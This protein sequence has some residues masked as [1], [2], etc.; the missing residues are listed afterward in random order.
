MEPKE[1]EN[2]T[3]SSIVEKDELSCQQCSYK[4][5]HEFDLSRHT[6]QMH[7]LLE[8]HSVDV[9]CCPHCE[10]ST[11]YLNNLKRHKRVQHDQKYR[12][13]YASSRRPA[14]DLRKSNAVHEETLAHK[15]IKCSFCDF[16]SKSNLDMKTHQAGHLKVNERT[17]HPFV[18]SG[19]VFGPQKPANN[20]TTKGS[21]LRCEKCK[22]EMLHEDELN[23][24]MKVFHAN[25][26][27][28]Q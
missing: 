7:S 21:N 12:T 4:A 15:I 11:Q 14:T 18:S 5:I 20:D 10:F 17:Q 27:E 13:F 26:S 8:D 1:T 9:H 22:K 19:Q 28:T 6:S 2:T 25:Y 16:A 3:K 24:H 23:L